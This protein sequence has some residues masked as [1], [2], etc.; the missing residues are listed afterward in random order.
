MQDRPK[1][2]APT[3]SVTRLFQDASSFDD[4]ISSLDDI[5]QIEAGLD[6]ATLELRA[7][8]LANAASDGV[9]ATC[10]PRTTLRTPLLQQALRVSYLDVERS[11][12]VI[13]TLARFRHD[14]GWPLTLAAAQ[15]ELAL[16]TRVHTIPACA[17]ARAGP[18]LD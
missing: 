3:Q 11:A 7:R 15:S 8:L 14:Q 18:P 4:R 17:R 5:V 16:R 10:E 6:D 2:C 1:W 9:D 13:R 12:R